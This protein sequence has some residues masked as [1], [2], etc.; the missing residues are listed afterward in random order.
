MFA[1]IHVR[2]PTTSSTPP[3]A[4]TTGFILLPSLSGIDGMCCVRSGN[5]RLKSGWQDVTSSTRRT[6]VYDL[7][8]DALTR[9]ETFGPLGLGCF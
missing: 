7:F 4:K 8:C 6:A 2:P 3:G 1:R 5:G 9:S